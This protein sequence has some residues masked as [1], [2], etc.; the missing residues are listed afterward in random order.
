MNYRMAVKGIAIDNTERL[1][2]HFHLPAKNVSSGRLLF[3]MVRIKNQRRLS[4]SALIC[5]LAITVHSQK[6]Q[7]QTSAA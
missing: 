5:E 3:G 2:A 7:H 6:C 4:Y 1:A